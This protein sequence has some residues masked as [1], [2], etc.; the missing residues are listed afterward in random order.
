M[1]DNESGADDLH[2]LDI[3]GLADAKVGQMVLLMAEYVAKARGEDLPR[4]ID[5]ILRPVV[6]AHFDAEAAKAKKEGRPRPVLRLIG[7][8]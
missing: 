8:D 2:D 4:Y 1:A 5:D 6:T 3:E 7:L